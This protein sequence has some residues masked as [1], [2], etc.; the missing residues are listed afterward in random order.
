MIGY[1]NKFLA[2]P[3]STTVDK[4]AV[5]QMWRLLI[6]LGCVPSAIALYF[7]LTIPESPRFTMDIEMRIR[8]AAIDIE[9][10]LAQTNFTV[11]PE[12]I[13]EQ[14]SAP[15]ATV[16]DFIAYFGKWSNMKILIGTAYS[17]F[18]IDVNI[19]ILTCINC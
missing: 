13:E 5:D 1:R 19:L 14:V 9:N 12:S 15:K 17:W 16:K 7:R 2:D 6:G 10:A 8:E 3:E 4:A 11:D 18:A